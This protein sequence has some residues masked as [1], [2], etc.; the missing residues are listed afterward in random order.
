MFHLIYQPDR[1]SLLGLSL[2]QPVFAQPAL[3][4]LRSMGFVGEMAHTPGEP[5]QFA[6]QKRAS[7]TTQGFDLGLYFEVDANGLLIRTILAIGVMPGDT[8]PA[9]ISLAA[10]R[11]KD[12]LISELGAPSAFMDNIEPWSL[13]S[14]SAVR[15]QAAYA[16]FWC[17]ADALP[18]Q[19]G[20]GTDKTSEQPDVDAFLSSMRRDVA[21]LRALA[22]ISASQG[23]VVATLDMV[24]AQEKP[25]LPTAEQSLFS[26]RRDFLLNL[27]DI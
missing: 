13:E 21:G 2:G 16:A 14:S 6:L 5:G 9:T 3:E 24:S 22:S 15:K 23:G 26:K 27:H 1:R 11:L 17:A 19:A 7:P 12:F 10:R 4:A 25:A 8:S 20:A 18:A